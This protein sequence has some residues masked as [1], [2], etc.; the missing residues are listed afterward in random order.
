[1]FISR[2]P[3]LLTR[4]DLPAAAQAMGEAAVGAVRTQMLEGYERPVYRTGALH[5]NVNFALDGTTVAIGNT[6]PYA[7][8]VHDGTCRMAGRPYLADGILNH[9]DALRQAAMRALR[10]QVA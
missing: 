9:A 3:E 2:L 7:I 1:M 8:P 10:H 6:L 5:D 4:L